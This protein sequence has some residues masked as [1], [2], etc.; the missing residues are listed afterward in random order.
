MTLNEFFR[1]TSEILKHG[2]I[3][4]D[5]FLDEYNTGNYRLALYLQKLACEA[6][7][8]GL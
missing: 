1:E 5:W 7:A 8:L 4:L 2:D 3:K 6:L